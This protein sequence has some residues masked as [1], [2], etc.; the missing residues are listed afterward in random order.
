MKAYTIFKSKFFLKFIVGLLIILSAC[1]HSP[2]KEL[3]NILFI[4]VDDLRPE[5]GCYGHSDMVTPNIDG[6]AESGLRFSNSFCNV[7]VCGASRASLMTGIRPTRS[8][9]YSYNS[10]AQVDVPDAIALHDHLRQQGYLTYSLGKILHVET[11][12]ADKWSAPP[13]KPD[14]PH[15]SKNYFLPH[16]IERQKQPGLVGPS[17]EREEVSDEFYVDGRISARAMQM[18]DSLKNVDKP[19]FLGVGFMRPHLPFTVPAKYWDLYPDSTI[20]LPDNYY[21]PENTPLESKFNSHEIRK[22]QYIPK[23]GPIPDTLALKLI[24]GYKASVSYVD[25]MVG[26]VIDKLKET[27]MYDNTIIVLWGDHGFMLGEH[28]LWCKHIT[29]DIAVRS[30]LIIRT[31]DGMVNKDVTGLVE[32]IDIY[33]TLC[34]L[35]GVSKPAQLDGVS[36]IEVINNSNTQPSKECVFPRYENMEAIKTKDYLYTQFINNE[37]E[38]TD[39]WLFDHQNDPEE[40][41]NVANLPGYHLV[42]DSLKTLLNKQ[43]IENEE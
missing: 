10:S 34:D 6:L 11:D 2:N 12:N 8:R 27:G 41:K 22:Y 32:F 28:A 4:A 15:T 20:T 35:V 31:P 43:I 26:R 16:N 19:F 7:P 36:L 9:F 25:A 30:P 33:P 37:E 1:K 17:Y 40:N 24:H 23:E 39:E 29:Y 13:W 21:W 3:P 42:V 5:L 38:V 18:L 14:V